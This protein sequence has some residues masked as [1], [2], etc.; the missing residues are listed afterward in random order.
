MTI[1]TQRELNLEYWGRVHD[2]CDAYNKQH[3]TSIKPQ[4]CV[5]YYGNVWN[6]PIKHPV[7]DD[8][9]YDLAVAIIEDTPVFVG[10]VLYSKDKGL[11]RIIK[12]GSQTIRHIFTNVGSRD[13]NDLTLTPPKHKRTFEL[14]GRQLTC[15]INDNTRST[16]DFIGHQFNFATYEDRDQVAYYIL[17][18]LENALDK[19]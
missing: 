2:M 9:N 16:L 1:K 19:E 6:L 17:D 7:F 18:I 4:Q 14:N 13:L 3:G 10:D 15:P 8:K 5:K 11:E 12:G